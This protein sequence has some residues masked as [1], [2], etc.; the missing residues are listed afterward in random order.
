MDSGKPIP[1][2]AQTPV[3]Q[4]ETRQKWDAQIAAT[5]ESLN[6]EAKFQCEGQAYSEATADGELVRHPGRALPSDVD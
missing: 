6:F 3:Q 5:R 2:D 1:Y 4:A